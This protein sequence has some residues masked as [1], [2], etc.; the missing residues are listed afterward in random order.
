[1]MVG[2]NLAYASRPSKQ[3][4]CCCVCDGRKPGYGSVDQQTIPIVYMSV[5]VD[6]GG[7]RDGGRELPSPDVVG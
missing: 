3:A 4:C 6:L 2:S 1:M 5:D 7:G